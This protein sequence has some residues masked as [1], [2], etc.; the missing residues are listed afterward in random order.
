M[1]GAVSHAEGWYN[2]RGG[3]IVSSDGAFQPAEIPEPRGADAIQLAW[4]V[5][6]TGG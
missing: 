4:M 6:K 5:K 3:G 2:I 1:G